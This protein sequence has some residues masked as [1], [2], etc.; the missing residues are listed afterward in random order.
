[1]W[2]RER[3][4]RYYQLGRD[5]IFQIPC[6]T[7]M[8]TFLSLLINAPVL[9]RFSESSGGKPVARFRY[10]CKPRQWLWRSDFKHWRAT[11][12]GMRN[13]TQDLE[14]PRTGGP[15][16]FFAGGFWPPHLLGKGLER[17]H[18]D[19]NWGWMIIFSLESHTGYT[20]TIG[21]RNWRFYY[22]LLVWL[23]TSHLMLLIFSLFNCKLEMLA[24]LMW[25]P[26]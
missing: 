22:F 4:S 17:T 11:V 12:H 18:G 5:Q 2:S 16:R 10:Q 25:L 20:Q 3:T 15:Q 6:S 24:S 13:T 21:F 23:W 14:G 7:T 1:M 26:W 8:R 9:L 19:E